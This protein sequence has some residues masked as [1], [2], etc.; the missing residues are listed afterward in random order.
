[1]H[2]R[3]RTRCYLAGRPDRHGVCRLY[4]GDYREC[5][6]DKIIRNGSYRDHSYHR[7]EQKLQLEVHFNAASKFM[8]L[9][10][11]CHALLTCHHHQPHWSL[12]LNCPAGLDMGRCSGRT[13]PLVT[14]SSNAPLIYAFRL[15]MVSHVVNYG[16]DPTWLS[17]NSWIRYGKYGLFHL[18]SYHTL[19]VL[20]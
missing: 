2:Q 5:W 14:K 1:M 13:T 11:A 17:R 4:K 7:R 6:S 8:F 19:N 3:T 12:L 15:F 18:L 20:A 16:A 9:K 10:L